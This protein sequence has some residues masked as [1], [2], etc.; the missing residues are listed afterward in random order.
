MSP[1]L[2]TRIHVLVLLLLG[3]ICVSSEDPWCYDKPSCGPKMWSYLGN[4]SGEKQSPINIVTK[5]TISDDCL[6]PINFVGYEDRKR[7][8]LLKN[9]GHYPEV[10]MK[11]GATISG[12]GLPAT[13]SL[14]SFHLHWGTYN[15]RGSEHAI[16]GL[17]QAMELHIVHT[18]NNLTME[19]A[20]EDPEGIAVLAFFIKKSNE[21]PIINAWKTLADL[22]KAIP[23]KGDSLKLDGEFSLGGL[24]SMSDLSSYYRYYGSLTTPNCNEAVIWTVYSEPIEVSPQTLKKFTNSLYFSNIKEGRLMQKNYRP[25]QPLNNRRVQHFKEKKYVHHYPEHCSAPKKF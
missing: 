18:K 23:E 3:G 10:E 21:T 2:N 22:M 11:K 7:P 5:K 13:Y 16:D 4:C 9:T 19:E 25:L 12:P 24:L 8:Q 6:G 15:L 1:T 20:R 17:H 14:K